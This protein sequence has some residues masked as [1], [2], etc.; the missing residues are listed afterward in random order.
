MS[1]R[2][3]VAYA[4]EFGST[5]EIAEVI[6]QTLRDTSTEVD[7]R[8]IIDVRD[9][10]PYQAVVVGSAIYNGAWLPEAVHFV[11]SFEATLSCL[12]VAY[13]A[14]SM[15][16]RNDTPAN[17]R[18]VLEYL[19]PVRALTPAVQPVDIGLFGGRL[20]YVNLPLLTRFYFWLQSRLP[21]GDYRTWATIQDWA[22]AIR[23]ALVVS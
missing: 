15:T 12:P 7:V 1:V 21:S 13:F 6:G 2:V 19:D 18:M 3:L 14:V 4:S 5:R 16:M 23:P 9:L 11:R 22:R 17:R 8:Q 10:A 20:Q